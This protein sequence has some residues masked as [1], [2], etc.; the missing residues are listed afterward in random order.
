MSRHLPIDTATV[1]TLASHLIPRWEQM[2][3]FHRRVAKEQILDALNRT[4]TETQESP[5]GAEG[6]NHD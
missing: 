4:Y 6:T 1:E 3:R 5:D 2:D